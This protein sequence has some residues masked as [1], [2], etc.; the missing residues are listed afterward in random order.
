MEAFV[1]WLILVAAVMVGVLLA[2]WVRTG[3]LVG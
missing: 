2:L 3:V 1:R